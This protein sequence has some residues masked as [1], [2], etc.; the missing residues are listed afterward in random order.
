MGLQKHLAGGRKI[1]KNKERGMLKPAKIED[2]IKSKFFIF[3]AILACLITAHF[4]VLTGDFLKQDD[5]NATFWSYRGAFFLPHGHPE[6]FN[7]AIDLFRPVGALILIISDYICI[8]IENAKFVKFFTIIF[9]TFASYLTYMWQ[10]KF[11]PNAKFFSFCFAILSFCLFASQ[12]HTSTAGYNGMVITLICGQVAII[13]FYK[14]L[15]EIKEPLIQRK[16]IIF[17][18]L[19]ILAGSMNYAISMMY[20]FLFL[21]IF[22]ISNIDKNKIPNIQIYKFLIK[23]TIFIIAIMVLYILMA[24]A[25]H[26]IFD[27]QQKMHGGYIRSIHIDWDIMNKIHSI[28]IM[29]KYSFNVFNLWSSTGINNINIF[30][31]VA[32]ITTFLFF[33]SI[34]IRLNLFNKRLKN[35]FSYINNFGSSIFIFMVSLALLILSYTPVL[36]L[37]VAVLDGN[38]FKT[39]MTNR[40]FVVTM[41][42]ILYIMMWSFNTIGSL[43]FLSTYNY[44]GKNFTFACILAFGI[45]QCNYSLENY[46]V[47]PHL[48]ELNYI[49][50]HIENDVLSIVNAGEKP[51]IVIIRNSNIGEVHYGNDYDLAINY[52]HNW[53]ISAT[54]YTLRQ[55]KLRSILTHKV[56]TW[57]NDLGIHIT[58]HWGELASVDDKNTFNLLTRKNTVIIDM[59]KLKI[60]NW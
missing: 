50:K 8:N 28:L 54:I 35:S 1:L 18:A 10:I 38:P 43:N 41:P 5:W 6:F 51:T 29:I 46:I 55:Y 9:M 17:S 36:P 42:F 26:L 22:Y 40:Y 44:I 7:A 37:E 16:Y 33:T 25:V 31:Y 24:K 52:S 14:A 19:L 39:I 56:I 15:M 11:S 23:S 45:Y 53:L 47:R 49:K 4:P 48:T 59:N 30:F 60:K 20:Y 21:F 12:L 3:T 2:F 13:Y 27:I 58:S 32:F 34:F 57:K